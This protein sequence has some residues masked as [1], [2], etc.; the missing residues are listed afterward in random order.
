MGF[1]Y[2]YN[3][4][5][6]YL[7]ENKIKLVPERRGRPKKETPELINFDQL[8]K[9]EDKDIFSQLNNESDNERDFINSNAESIFEGK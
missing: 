6:K 2:W 4:L 3:I 7:K 9:I 8:P 1:D 5:A